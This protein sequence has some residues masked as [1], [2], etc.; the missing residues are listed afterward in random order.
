MRE[1]GSKVTANNDK[2]TISFDRKIRL[3]PLHTLIEGYLQLTRDQQKQVDY[4]LESL[5]M[6]NEIHEEYSEANIDRLAVLS[7][8]DL[9]TKKERILN[10]VRNR[11]NPNYLTAR[12]IQELY[13]H[14]MKEEVGISTIQTNL[15]RLVDAGLVERQEGVNPIEYRINPKKAQEIPKVLM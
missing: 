4:L 7:L 6:E 14:Y 15:N 11:A 8:T 1:T 12:E 2:F 13:Q 5:L 3:G 10:I 9:K